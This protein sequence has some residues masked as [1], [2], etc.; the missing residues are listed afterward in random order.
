M[1]NCQEIGTKALSPMVFIQLRDYHL[2]HISLPQFLHYIEEHAPQFF[3]PH[4]SI[5]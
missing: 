5:P 1:Q 4:F 2:G 3:D